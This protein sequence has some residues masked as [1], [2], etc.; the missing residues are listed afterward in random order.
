MKVSSDGTQV[1]AF[2][3]GRVTELEMNGE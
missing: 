2:F 3:R 1:A